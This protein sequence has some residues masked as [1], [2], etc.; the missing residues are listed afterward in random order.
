MYL[1]CLNNHGV[2][3]NGDTSIMKEDFEL[4]YVLVI[5]CSDSNKELITNSGYTRHMTPNK[6]G[7]LMNYVIKM[8]D[9]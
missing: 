4:S 9:M 6:D 2:K 7:F 3:D 5:S 8:V 1:E